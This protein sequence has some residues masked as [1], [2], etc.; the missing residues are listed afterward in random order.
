MTRNPPLH[1]QIAVAAL[2]CLAGLLVPPAA[3]A[4]LRKVVTVEGITEYQLDNGLRV[5]L[6]PDLSTS[7]VTVNLTVLVGSRHE[8]YG[9]TGMAHLLEHMV[10]KGT[11]RHRDIPKALRDHGARFNGTT[12]VDRTNYFE[13]MPA[14]DENLEFAIGLEADRLVNSYVKREDLVSEMTVVR[15]EFEAGENNPEGVLRQRMVRVA[16]DWHNYGKSTIGNRSDIER[17][18]IEN[19]RAF[20]RKYYQ[21]DNAVLIVAGKFDPERALRLV[22]KYFGVLKRPKRRLA[23]TYTEEPPQDGERTV[24]LRRVGKVGAVGVVYH[25]CAGPHEDYPAVAVLTDILTAEPTGRLYKALVETKLVTRATGVASAY[26]DPGVLQI[27]APVSSNEQLEAVRRTLIEVLESQPGQPLTDREVQR[28]R[29]K[30]GNRIE[31]LLTNSNQVGTALSDAVAQGDWRLLFLQRDRLARVTPADVARVAARYLKA[32]NR[33]VGLYVPTAAAQRTEVPATPDVAELVKGYRGSRT[34]ARGEAF[35]PTPQNIEKRVRR[36]ELPGGVKAA[37]LPK[38]TRGAM[39][40][41]QLTL[42]YGNPSSLQ[43]YAAAARILGPLMLRGTKGHTRHQLQDELERL[44]ARLGAGAG[45][46]GRRG[47]RSGGPAAG[48]P[49][50]LTFSIM[51]QRDNLPAVLRLLGEVLREP[52]F[53]PEEFEVLKRQAKNQLERGATEPTVLAMVYLQRRMNPYPKDDV[54]YVPTVGESLARVEGLTCD[55]VRELYRQL[56]G[57]H[58]EL[59]VVGDFDPDAT[60]RQV[61]EVLQGWKGSVPYE[62]VAPSVPAGGSGEKQVIHTPDKANALYLAGLRF[63]LTDQ[64]PDYPALKLADYIFGEAAL[65]SRLANRVRGKE[66]LS[67]AVRSQLGAGA[68]DRAGVFQIFAITNPRNMPKLDRTVAEELHKMIKDGVTETELE[69]AKKAYAQQLRVQ[70]SVDGFLVGLLGRE[71]HAGRT[72]AYYA[73]LEKKIRALTPEQVGRAFRK[74]IDP[75][76]LVIVQAGDFQSGDT[77]RPKERR[78]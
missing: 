17:V 61:A 66:G 21:P 13:T 65:A 39:I 24:V 75:K 34:V 59:A 72:F 68:L 37:L 14:A 20:Y 56:G 44:N 48:A 11:P 42:R 27:I 67:Y 16:Y 29:R 15:N 69:E 77:P 63:A 49:G 36:L 58:G 47:R 43:G 31:R 55:R 50:E 33:T 5:L 32:S 71:L 6:F 64:D 74:Y 52:T 23:D 18:P 78:R 7:A 45:G 51:C 35:D 41:A 4:D 57:Q 62:R 9:E 38:K 76:R 28:A 8:G 3:G 46:G 25:V 30:L 22:G 2:L 10:F 1:R 40:F 70:R 26:H 60:S 19:L 53:P 73:D 12:W 54:R